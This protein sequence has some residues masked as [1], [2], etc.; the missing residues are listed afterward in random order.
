MS[1]PSDAPPDSHI[2]HAASLRYW[3]SVAANAKTML[4]MLGSY[5]WY[6]RIDLRG[7]KTFLGKVRRMIPNCPT[8][9]KLPLGVDCGA[10]VGRVTEGLLSQVC[11]RVDAVE[12][13]EKF[14]EVIRNSELKRTGVV[15]DI[16]TMGLEN[17]Y[18]EKNKYDLIWTQ[19]CVGHLTDVQLREYFV[20]CREALTETGIMVVK[21]NQSTDPNGLDMFDE[22]DSS[23]TRT[24]EKLRTLFKEAGLVL[25]ASELQ[26]GFPKNFKLLPVRFYALR[27]ST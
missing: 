1:T 4:G 16:Y 9:G 12:P 22:E 19:F 26:L 25:V 20:R 18:P 24:D 14:T 11:E 5:P 7:S 13:I 23:V 17:W 8:E 27:P 2:D 6:T 15:R 10:G 21:E 3:N